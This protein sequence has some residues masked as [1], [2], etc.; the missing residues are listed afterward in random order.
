M[1]R[2]RAVT[3]V[4]LGGRDPAEPGDLIP[5]TY[6]DVYG[7]EQP[8]DFERLV[9]LGAAEPA[10]KRDEA[11]KSLNSL[12]REELNQIAADAGVPEPEELPSKEAVIEAIE[13]AQSSQG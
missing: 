3:H 11:K 8:V 2:H 5:E 13:T 7:K 9:K 10:D 6:L 12:K 4:M 1:G